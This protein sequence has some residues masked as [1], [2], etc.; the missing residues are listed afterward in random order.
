M[1]LLISTLLLL[2]TLT[3]PVS[4][5]KINW[6]EVTE[7][8]IQH[9]VTLLKIDTRN[10]PGN[11][12][13]VAK[14][15]QEVLHSEGI[16]SELFALEPSRA[17]LIARLKGDGSKRPLLV[18]GHTDVVGV[19]E[20][21]WSVDPFAAVRKDG[22]I[23][24]R[25][26][27]DDKDNV[28]ASLMVM[29]MLKRLNVPLTRDVIF[30][31]EAGEEATPH[32]GIDFLVEHHWDK[33]DSEYCLA[34][35]GFV[36]VAED[37]V[38]Y[39]AIAT[40]EKVPGRARL[41]A[42]GTAGH[43]SI[44]R[45]DN[46]VSKLSRA[47]A[48]IA[49]W[50]PPMRLNDTTRE[51]FERLSG[52]ST[53]EDAF[54]YRHLANPDKRRQIESYLATH[55]PFHNSML[56]TS[57]VPTMLDAGFRINVIPS[58]AEAGIDIRAVPDE[59]ITEFYDD[60]LGVVNDPDVEL[61]PLPRSRPPAPPSEMDND[62]FR[63]LEK[64]T[65]RL[66]PDAVTLPIMLTGA[67]DMAQI[68][69]KGV[70]AYGFGPIRNSEDFAAGRGAHGDDERISENALAELVQFLWYAVLEIATEN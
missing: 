66:Y 53:E 67:T 48:R 3:E 8:T 23:Y 6:E 68:R 9:F 17:N 14:Y 39:V 24:G 29:L 18:M 40:T 59:S 31:A 20:E 47:V 46:A 65:K 32:V 58:Q 33:L 25:G 11:E 62:M 56:R 70:Q 5:Q 30:L 64:V 49:A 43:G 54:R 2:S 7:E 44:P 60:L 37:R 63:A 61:I 52:L 19:Q 35:G 4:A 16:H 13:K 55:E 10:P 12:T 1:G 50:Q 26:S 42:H 27:L 34:E 69:S 36:S 51:Y 41:I 45:K 21:R 28:T 15:L 38:R 57:V 22:F